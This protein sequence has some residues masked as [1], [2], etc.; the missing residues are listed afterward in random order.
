MD[1]CGKSFTTDGDILCPRSPRS[2][3]LSSDPAESVSGESNPVKGLTVFWQ[4]LKLT[5]VD[6]M[7]SLSD[8][9]DAL[10]GGYS[11]DK[12]RDKVPGDANGKTF[13]GFVDKAL[14]PS[15]M[16]LA[17]MVIVLVVL[18]RV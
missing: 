17:V 5:V 14:G 11:G 3:D 7:T 13:S 2:Y 16:G 15:L 6:M 9:F 4:E 10:F 12:M 18:K 1:K 8:Y